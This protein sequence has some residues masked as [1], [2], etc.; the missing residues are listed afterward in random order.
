MTELKAVRA[1]PKEGACE[2]M[3]GGERGG[4]RKER[5][6]RMASG[7]EGW[8]WGVWRGWKDLGVWEGSAWVGGEMRADGRIGEARRPSEDQIFGGWQQGG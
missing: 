3:R 7:E 5:V 4:A 1:A 2:C 6:T 8:S